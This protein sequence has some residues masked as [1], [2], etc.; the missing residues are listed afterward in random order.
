MKYVLAHGQYCRPQSVPQAPSTNLQ[1][2]ISNHT[3]QS[4]F[5]D[6]SPFGGFLNGGNLQIID[7]NMQ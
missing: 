1:C 2:N 5:H 4:Q 3:V 6:V 7:F